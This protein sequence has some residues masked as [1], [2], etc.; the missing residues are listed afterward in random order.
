[1]LNDLISRLNAREPLPPLFPKKVWDAALS[2]EILAAPLAP[3]VRA[4]LLLWND[5]LEASHTIS[6][7]INT[8]TGSFWHAIMHR[9]EGDLGNSLYWWN[10][11]GAHPAFDEIYQS[12]QAVLEYEPDDDAQAFLKVLWHAERWLPEEFVRHCGRAQREGG[13][14]WLT[15]VQ[16]AEIE[17]LL[18]WC[19]KNS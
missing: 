19:E 11:T 5:D 10:R 6:Q 3:A 12:A 9:R 8:P 1:M 15:R 17:T 13:E 18:R 16:V 4:G 7:G 14:G 2:R